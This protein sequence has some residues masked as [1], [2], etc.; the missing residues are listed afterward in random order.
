MRRR[1]GDRYDGGSIALHW[2]IAAL[3][4]FNLGLGLSHELLPRAWQVM[5]I[6]KA[7]GITVLALSVARLAWRLTHQAPH[8]PDAMPDVQKALAK[9]V[10]WTFYLLLI[11]LPLSGWTFSSDPARPRPFAW[12]GLFPVPTLPATHEVAHL[13]RQA[14]AP[15][16]YLVAALVLLHVAAALRHH[17]VRRD[18]VLARMLPLVSRHG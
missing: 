12:F 10:H 14:H 15:M 6:H 7:V 18:R 1:R 9:A 8:L 16:G 2:A 4:L 3:V 11:L 5:P 17:F 13:A